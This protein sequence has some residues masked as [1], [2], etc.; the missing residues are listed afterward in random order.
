[1]NTRNSI[2]CSNPK[3]KRKVHPSEFFFFLSVVSLYLL[4][5]GKVTNPQLLLSPPF[6][7]E[8]P[9]PL[10]PKLK[11]QLVDFPPSIIAAAAK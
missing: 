11:S 6:F 7:S 2:F 10:C 4:S 5:F 3:T 9:Q 8:S 1:M